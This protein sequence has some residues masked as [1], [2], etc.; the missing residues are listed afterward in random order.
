MIVDVFTLVLLTILMSGILINNTPIVQL[1][2]QF[3]QILLAVLLWFLIVMIIFGIIFVIMRG[4]A[5][6]FNKFFGKKN[7]FDF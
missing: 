5:I 1:G 7:K 4:L 2:G 6:V 3:T